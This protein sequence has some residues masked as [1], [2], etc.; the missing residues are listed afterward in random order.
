[1]RVLSFR[2]GKCILIEAASNSASLKFCSPVMIC[3]KSDSTLQFDWV[4]SARK[5]LKKT[6]RTFV[7]IHNL[8]PPRHVAHYDT[9]IGLVQTTV[10]K[11][12][13]CRSSWQKVPTHTCISHVYTKS[14][15]TTIC[16]DFNADAASDSVIGF[17]LPVL[18]MWRLTRNSR[19]KQVRE[20]SLLRCII[21]GPLWT[22]A[23]AWHEKNTY[24]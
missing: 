8:S 5:S 3:N 7:Q 14:I 15:V 13:N 12:E 17:T 21:R 23:V 4:Q 18:Q 11:H 16:K 20:D 6:F 24:P 2:I 10:L 9:Q 1:M 22:D 19:C